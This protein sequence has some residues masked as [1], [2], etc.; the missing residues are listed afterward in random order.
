MTED[1]ILEPEV[2]L[3]VKSILP[4]QFMTWYEKNIPRIHFSHR[5]RKLHLSISA[6]QRLFCTFCLSAQRDVES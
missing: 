1:L 4:S 6:F 3:M 5:G 2:S